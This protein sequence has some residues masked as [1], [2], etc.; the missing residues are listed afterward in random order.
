MRSDILRDDYRFAPHRS[1]L[2]SLGYTDEELARPLIGVAN[3]GNELVP[4]HQHLDMITAAVKNGIYLA[5]GTPF[6][7]RTIGVCDGIAMGH[8]GMKYSLASREI[9]ADSCEI[10]ARAYPFDGLV[11]VPNCDKIVPGML[12][13]LLRLNIPGLLVS[14]GPMLAGNFR[15][16]KVDLISVFEAVGQRSVE[17]ITDEDLKALE[18]AACPGCGS[19]A[20]MFTANS[21]NCLTEGLGLGLPGN[22][23]IPAVD[24]R[25][26][27]LAKEAGMKVMELV[28]KNKKPREIAD[29][30]AFANAIVLDMALGASSNTVLHLPAIAAEA[31]INLSLAEFD[32][33]SKKTPNLCRISPAGKYRMEDL[34]QAGGIPAVFSELAKAKLLDLS[35]QTVSGKTI[36]EIASQNKPADPEVIRPIENPHSPE[37]GIAILFGNLAPDGA[38]VKQSAVNKN[39]LSHTGPARVFDAEEAALDAILNNQIKDGSVIIIR[40]EGPKGG[41]GMREMLSVTSALV[42]AGRDDKIA[43]ITDGRFSGG[44]RGLAIGHVSPEAAAGGPCA[45]VIDNDIIEIDLPRRVLNLKV[46]EA[47]LEKRKKSW[48]PAEPKVKEGYL[49]RYSRAV[50]SAAQGAVVK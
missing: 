16:K 11:F 46:S 25:R 34:D 17:K 2:K 28:R 35:A 31:G 21:M 7:F 24:S 30:T 39:H 13:A 37:G 41:P 40:Y 43:L 15:G 1:L 20:G 23:T 48:K 47:E 45:L 18:E 8:A 33:I 22:G 5:G 14:G 29:S 38:V 9:I 26:V 10:V 19:C 32:L 6:E 36:G 42:G 3:S 49:Y 27:R 12:M 4:G 44:T 50:S